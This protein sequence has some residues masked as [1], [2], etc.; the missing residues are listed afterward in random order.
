MIIKGEIRNLDISTPKEINK[1]SLQ[2][3][4]KLILNYELRKNQ[5]TLSMNQVVNEDLNTLKVAKSLIKYAIE[6]NKTNKVDGI[7]YINYFMSKR[8]FLHYNAS[9]IYDTYEYNLGNSH[10]I[11]YPKVGT[12]VTSHHGKFSNL[13]IPSS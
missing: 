4:D 5:T 2:E 11:I 10:Q 13:L 12:I 1:G 8:H 7:S 3:V 9:F 6:N